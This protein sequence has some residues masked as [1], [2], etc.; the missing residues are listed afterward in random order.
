M[1]SAIQGLIL[2][3]V[4]IVLFVTQRIP[5]T[6]TA[7]LSVVLFA[8]TGTASYET[9]F[10]GFSNDII[11]M[12]IGVLIVG[13]AMLQSGLAARIGQGC[14]CLSKGNERRFLLYILISVSFTSM[15]VD[16]TTTVAIMLP[17][18]AAA[19]RKSNGSVRFMNFVIP[20]S[21]AAMVGGAC[22]MIGCTVNLTGQSILTEYTDYSFGMT[23]FTVATLPVL[24]VTILYVMFLGY[25]CGGK[26]W[27]DEKHLEDEQEAVAR[28][29]NGG[30]SAASGKPDRKCVLMIAVMVVM[31]SLFLFTDLPL[32]LSACIAALLCV[33]FRLVD[34]R[35][36]LPKMD[37]D[38]VL[39]LACTLGL[40]AAL[41][42]CGF[43]ELISGAFVSAFGN[44]IPPLLILVLVLIVSTLISQFMGNS[45]V[46]LVLGAAVI[47][48]VVSLGYNPLAITMALILGSSFAWMTPIAGA[49]IGISYSAGYQFTDYVKY[50]WPLTILMWAVLIIW[51]PIVFPFTA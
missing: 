35:E 36:A 38:V 48:I 19:S 43:C 24:A 28:F 14:L 22:L 46:V 45:T 29:A 21:L 17:V 3:I 18:I 30:G 42:E 49:C 2:L 10:S 41:R 47:P 51:L 5:A 37:W 1:T 33:I 50:T 26:I 12:L 40:A 39:R 6:A 7:L 20:T 23:D 11:I 31:V 9:C 25:R 27:G 15:F 16:N 34:L 32:G 13:Q 8:V 4:V 44:D